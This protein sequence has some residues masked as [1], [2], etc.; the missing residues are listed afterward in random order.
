MKGKH[1]T[2]QG[3]FG[4]FVRQWRERRGITQ[5]Q[6]AR[7]IEREQAWWSKI[8]NH[9]GE[10]Y[11]PAPDV[12][13]R[14][15]EVLDAPFAALVLSAYGLEAYGMEIEPQDKRERVYEQIKDLYVTTNLDPQLQ[16]MLLECLDF[17]RE[18]QHEKGEFRMQME[19]FRDESGEPQL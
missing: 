1:V 8:E 5:R 12:L 16:R 10:G 15:S 19:L 18:L 11:L 3:Y 17:V 2:E 7:L 14:L 9:S 13:R 4:S 6:L